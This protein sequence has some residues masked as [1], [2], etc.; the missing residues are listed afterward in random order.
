MTVICTVMR[1]TAARWSPRSVHATAHYQGKQPGGF[2]LVLLNLILWYKNDKE[3]WRKKL[4][5]NPC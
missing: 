1:N 5:R 4:T 2:L 3:L